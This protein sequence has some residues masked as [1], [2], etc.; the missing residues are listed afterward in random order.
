MK[1][2]SLVQK[3]LGEA[4]HMSSEFETISFKNLRFVFFHAES[5]SFNHRVKCSSQLL[6]PDVMVLF[7]ELAVLFAIDAI[8]ITPL[9]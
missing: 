5:T 3:V 7:F 6:N 2:K 8:I 1:E 4:W 9:V